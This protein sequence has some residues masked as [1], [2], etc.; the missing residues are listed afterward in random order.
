MTESFLSGNPGVPASEPGTMLCSVPVSVPYYIIHCSPPAANA[1]LLSLRLGT[2]RFSPA[3]FQA[4]A[5][6]GLSGT[7]SLMREARSD[8]ID[9]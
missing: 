7:N 6:R 8:G 3:C 1:V 4:L 5:G 9:L 2:R